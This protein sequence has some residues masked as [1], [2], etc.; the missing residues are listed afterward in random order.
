MASDFKIYWTEEA[1]NNLESI[2]EYLTN[3][4]TQREV[5]NFKKTLGKQIELIEN[6]PLLF[7]ISEFN[8]KLRKAVLSKQTTI[9]YTVSGQIIYLVYL[10]NSR[11]GV[12]KI[13]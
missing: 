7:P 9:F 3:R 5:D 2:L 10:F 11:Q 12:D 4:W 6:N 13:I 8:N 1:V